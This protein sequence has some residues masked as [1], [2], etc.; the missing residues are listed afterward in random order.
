MILNNQFQKVCVNRIDLKIKVL[1]ARK[2]A[3]IEAIKVDK[4]QVKR[5]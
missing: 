5:S 4:K 2:T 1:D 3:Y